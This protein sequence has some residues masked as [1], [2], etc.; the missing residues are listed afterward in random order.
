MSRPSFFN[1]NINRSYPLLA[2]PTN[3]TVPKYAVADFGCTFAS[4][5][6]YDELTDYVYLKEIRKID[7]LIEF[8]FHT[9]ATALSGAA[10]VFRFSAS[11]VKYTTALADVTSDST[12]S[13]SSYTIEDFPQDCDAEPLWSGYMSCG[14]L[15]KLADDLTSDISG[16]FKVEPSVVRNHSLGYVRSLTVYNADRTRSDSS[17]NCRDLCWPFDIADH[18]QI[19]SCL[20]GNIAFKEGYNCEIRQDA[21]TNTI[22]INAYVGSGEG[23]VCTTP[24]IHDDEEAP[25]GRTTLDGGLKC[26]EVVRSVN[27]VG[28]RTIKIKG[29]DGV[30]VTSDLNNHK[31]IINVDM[32]NMQLCTDFRET[33]ESFDVSSYTEDPCDCGPE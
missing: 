30:S 14:D 23:E 2:T 18:Y 11:D 21:A 6:G 8:E 33:G 20:T 16:E 27:G 31:V 10:L 1:D 29:L 9:T 4:G 25:A 28:G 26:S 7:S 3:D 5:A 17:S 32:L 19:A 22:V 13:S 15:A 24:T 12:I